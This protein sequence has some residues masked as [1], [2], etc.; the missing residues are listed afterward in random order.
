M[1]FDTNIINIGRGEV[2]HGIMRMDGSIDM[3]IS[4]GDKTYHKNFSINGDGGVVL[5]SS[6]KAV[7]MSEIVPITNKKIARLKNAIKIY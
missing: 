7:I 2:V 6:D 5:N 1:T 4:D 3:Y